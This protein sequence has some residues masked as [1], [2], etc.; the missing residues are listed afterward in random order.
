MKNAIRKFFSVFVAVCL[1]TSMVP[2]SAMADQGDK[3]FLDSANGGPAAGDSDSYGPGQG[4]FSWTHGDTATGTTKVY[5]IL[6]DDNFRFTS[7]SPNLN[8]MDP[9]DAED[10]TQPGADPGPLFAQFGGDEGTYEYTW[11]LE[12]VSIAADGTYEYS[13]HAPLP[14]FTGIDGGTYQFGTTNAP[15]TP[16]KGVVPTD[17]RFE[18]SIT[19]ADGLAKESIYRYTLTL[20]DTS[21]PSRNEAVAQIMVS[22]FGNYANQ[23]LYLNQDQTNPTSVEGFIYKDANLVNP[24]VPLLSADAV[25]ETSPIYAAIA[26]KAAGND[27]AQNITQ[28]TQLVITNIENLPD[29][30]PAYKLD[31][32]VHLAIPDD[33]PTK[34]EQGDTVKVYRYDQKTGEVVEYE[35]KVVQQTDLSGN[36]VTDASG[37]PVLSIELRVMGTSAALGS[38]AIGYDS[39]DGSFTVESSATE[40][41]TISPA[42]T[43]T[44]A[45]GASPKYVLYAQSGYVL[46]S[47][48]IECD[49][50]PVRMQSGSL[51]G[52][53]FTLDADLYQMANGETWTVTG[54]FEAP[55]PDADAYAVSA[56]LTGQGSGTMTVLSGASGSTPYTV[57]MNGSVP[58]PGEDA[59]M[60]PSRSG[61]YLEF[62]PGSGFKLKSLRINGEEYTVVGTS[63]FIS[64][65]T[66]NVN[67]EAEYEEGLPSPTMTRD[68]EVSV[69][70]PSK[71]LVMDSDGNAVGSTT[72]K[73]NYGST[74]TI[75]IAPKDGYMVASAM[76]YAGDSTEGVDLAGQITQADDMSNLQIHNVLEDMRV[77]IS[78]KAVDSTVTISVDG[79]GGTVNPSGNVRLSEGVPQRVTVTPDGDDAEGLGYVLGS[80]TMNGASISDFL[81]SRNSGKFYTFK[82]VRADVQSADYAK[83]PDG[84][85]DKVLYINDAQAAILVKFDAKTPPAPAYQ[86]I[87]TEV[88]APGGG[89]ITPTQR[90]EA[91]SDAAVWVFPDQGK[92]VKSV[93]LDGRNVTTTLKEDG[94]KLELLNV[95]TDHTVVVTFEDGDSPLSNKTKYT[96]HPSAGA[97]GS[98]TPASDTLVYE[99]QDQAFTFTPATGYEV[100]EVMVDGLPVDESE[101]TATSYV[102][103]DVRADHN[104][105]VTFK[106]SAASGTE[107][108]TY[109]VEVIA[110]EHG[111]VSPAGVSEIARGSNLPITIVPDSGYS[112]DKINVKAKTA[113]GSGINM[114][115]SMVNGVF[116][117][118]D[119]QDDLIVEITFK[120]GTDPNQPS[121]D[122]NN[123]VTLGARNAEV[124]PGIILNP[125][126]DGL[127]FY[128]EDG[129][130]H[131]N[132]NQ[133]FTIQVASGYSL[134]TVTVNGKTLNVTEIGDGIYKFTVPKEDITTQMLLKVTSSTQP[135]STQVVDLR[136][137]TVTWTGN[138]TV[139]PS[140]ITKGVV[141][142]ETG[143][144]QTFYFI[145]ESGNRVG[146]V[147]VNGSPVTLDN[148]AYT[149]P[150]VTQDMRIEAEFVEDPNAPEPPATAE[151]SVRLGLDADGNPHGFA[152][153]GEG[154]SAAKVVVG[155]KVSISFKPDSGYE[156]HVYEGTNASGTEVT[157][158]LS[159]GTLHVTNVPASGKH[160]YVEFTPLTQPVSYQTVTASSGPNGTVSPEGTLM[161]LDGSDMT[162]TF[163][164]D[165]GYTIDKVWITRG[166]GAGEEVS[167][168]VDQATMSYTVSN[169][170]EKVDVWASFKAG[171]PD[172]TKVSTRDIT[173]STSEGGSVSPTSMKAATGTMATFTFIPLRGYELDKVT[174][175]TKDVTAQVKAAGG[176]YQFTVSSNT[177][178]YG[179][180]VPSAESNPE[181]NKHNVFLNASEHGTVSPSGVVSVPHGG[182]VPFTMIP[183]DGYKIDSVVISING[184]EQPQPQFSGFKYTLFNVTADM[185]VIVNFTE[186]DPNESIE[187]PTFYEITAS[188]SMDGSISPSGI[189]KVAEGGMSMYSFEP[190]DGFKLSYLVV[191]GENVPA[192][193]VTRGQYSFTGVTSDHT[194][195]AVF[196]SVDEQVTDFVTVNAGNPSGGTITPAGAKLVM[197]GTSPQYT[198]SAFF[199]YTLAD[200][201]VNDVSIFTDGADGNK[202]IAPV[203]TANVSWS[204]STLTLKN[205]QADTSIVAMFRQTSTS[206]EQPDVEYSR[207][208]VTGAG[209][210]SGGSTSFNNGTT[211]I[212]ALKPGQTLDISIIPDEGKAIDSI[213]IHGADGKDVVLT[214]DDAK[215][216]WR[217]GYVTLTAE[218]VNYEVTLSVTFRNQ[219]DAEK[220]EIENGTFTPAKFR[221]INA[222]AFGR[223]TIS[224]HGA[225]KVAQNATAM[226][227]MV[228]MQ[229]YEL[230]A[231]H[232]DGKDALGMLK[233]SRVYTF[234]PGTQDQ[235]I[236]AT[237]SLLASADQGVSYKVTTAIDAQ[238]GAKGYASISEME[239]AAGGSATLYFW[240]EPK[241]EAAGIAGSKLTSLSV[242]TRDN[243]GNVVENL[244]F[245]YNVPEYVL[246]NISGDTTVTA[247]FDVLGPDETTWTINEAY[248]EASVS[249]DGG[250]RVS[251]ASATVPKG[252]EQTFNF[253]PDAG[254]EVSFLR[255]NDEIVY[256]DA[257][258]RS[259][260]MIVTSTDQSAPNTLEVTFKNVDAEAADVT[261]TAK[262]AVRVV[263]GSTASANASI[264]PEERTVPAGTPV[265]FYVM[266]DPGYTIESV[267]VE[268]RQIPFTGVSNADSIETSYN[269]GWPLSRTT[270]AAG[271][272]LDAAQGGLYAGG[273]TASPAVYRGDA[274]I[275]QMA[276]GD[277]FYSV[278]AITVPA[279]NKD[280]TAYV[281][282]RE[283]TETH[284]TYVDTPVHELEVTSEGGGTV[285]P[286]GL[287][288]LPTGTVENIRLRAFTGYYLESVTATYEDGTTEDLTNNVTGSNV[289]ITMGTQNMKVHAKF[290][291]VGEASFVHVSL[292]SAKDPFGNDITDKVTVSPP[293]TDE[294]GNPTNFVRDPDGTGPGTE[295]FFSTNEVGPNGRPLVLD[296]V[297]YNGKPVSFLEDSNYVRVQL[298]AG[299][300]FDVTFRELEEGHIEIKPTTYTVS[301]EVTSGQGTI[302]E[303]PFTVTAGSSVTIGFKPE[304]GWMIDTENCYDWYADEDGGEEVAHKIDATSIANGS[305]TVKGIDRN[306]RVTVAFVQ[307]VDLTIGWTNGDNG[308]VTPNTMNG[309]PIKVSKGESIPFIVAP[310]EGYDVESVKEVVADVESDVT[311]KLRQ[312]AATTQQLLA[313][314]GNEGFSVKNTLEGMGVTGPVREGAQAQ[315]LEPVVQADNT[316][317]GVAYAEAPESPTSASPAL[318][319]FNYAY[320]SATAPIQ[321]NTEV[322]ATWTDEENVVKKEER[323]ITVEI[324]GDM[325]GTVDPMVGKG[326]DGEYITFTFL[327]DDGWAVRF[328]EVMRGGV[329]ERFE[330]DSAGGKEEFTYGPIDGDGYIKVGFDS[331]AHPGTND[332]LSRYLRTLQ[333]LA[334]TG[335]L[336]APVIGTLLGIAVLACIMAVITSRRR[337]RPGKHA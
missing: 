188:A 58:A 163:L 129:T 92:K 251:P 57:P 52:N 127:V 19:A 272:E 115:E 155:G 289:R 6:K 48:S 211:V 17:A 158:N 44:Y 32:T 305:Y 328:I 11:T 226:F 310:Y 133:D 202:N 237:F 102:M 145:P 25:P 238:N 97:G 165:A 233:D 26:D 123:L 40:G 64:V 56:H 229:G 171:Q 124:D 82:I 47:I 309:E 181:A 216:V 134:S 2:A 164:G 243:D 195:H 73:V 15:A 232:I 63:Y 113:T 330:S 250:G 79:Q 173:A 53:V 112:V 182:S 323:T 41:G 186:L 111:S 159:N 74:G 287:G 78:F 69:D 303:G 210:G 317:N 153:L 38:F 257:N 67:I 248:V 179:T 177:T 42:E 86:T 190:H 283:I 66:E 35:G 264:W 61:V 316:A 76:V 324:V 36:P 327:P 194:I 132:V 31:L 94:A 131:A 221:T 95:Q 236:E 286:L 267:E 315:S 130:D 268:G 84:T 262:V 65:L 37:N 261:V 23:K 308:Y 184:V 314:P 285:S 169:I 199:G 306:H 209:Q 174:D 106:K 296:T 7:Q 156:T 91:G 80:I 235:T 51:E 77:V 218:Q 334:Q 154:V 231:L 9:A 178:I 311:G 275:M 299:G 282:T 10:K 3:D 135:P 89:S 214:G 204:N 227:S 114:V 284:F 101:Y 118:F 22:T 107:R 120:R 189:I 175:G 312:S 329:V 240:P 279:S 318:R 288:F 128:K 151:V 39:P 149:I 70:D 304:E 93:T 144:S 291:P 13:A 160:Y 252:C 290:I 105:V 81:T 62:N 50:S 271:E 253:F 200:I 321:N 265:S 54:I 172:G 137:I 326:V 230:S 183:D 167:A 295:F 213:T 71:G 197:K 192:S 269:S 281:T 24:T 45:V 228:P 143:E 18:H 150:A 254:Y 140:G 1:C 307:F 20:T 222:Q 29:N 72:L 277:T 322:W 162:F 203:N 225:V 60:M 103:K 280:I 90:V 193:A 185:N 313:M 224:P 215:D 245:A 319:N 88:A 104:L 142:V 196:C 46:A 274:G 141:R 297:L 234:T 21:N 191:D 331:I 138:G 12:D 247:H 270:T 333:A 198:V 166:D 100:S 34:P 201:R 152:S 59:I 335:D 300:T 332:T 293:L 119:V 337:R 263:N 207:V 108:D 117:Q 49:G 125:Q 180:F 139:S 325:G 246:A 98:V 294:N 28:P 148:Y 157:S 244:D 43:R 187:L 223:G 276:E 302:T 110:G 55:E 217:K 126:V 298:T 208:T 85:T 320:G 161:V 260:S 292:G 122:P 256:V 109:T 266:P 301:G 206:P 4:D 259:Y 14:T 170:T 16:A 249:S 219:T 168:Q 116:T 278:Y 68:I 242:V 336:T 8:F 96:I 87:T 147:L 241:N 212:E 30:E 33:L 75:A 220:Q 258:V 83:N 273:A 136:T 255:I 239:V 121:T 176:V 99:G 5:G 146:T 205:I 27:P